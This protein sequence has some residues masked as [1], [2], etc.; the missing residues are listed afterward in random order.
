LGSSLCWPCCWLR[1]G[2]A[3]GLGPVPRCCTSAHP[4]ESV[5]VEAANE[6]SRG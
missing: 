1:E 6:G 2:Y 5:G 4:R 3:Q